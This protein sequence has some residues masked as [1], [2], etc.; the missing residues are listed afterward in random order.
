MP[1]NILVSLPHILS[2]AGKATL[3]HVD[4]RF[5]REPGSLVEPG[6]TH[7]ICEPDFADIIWARERARMQVCIWGATSGQSESQKGL[8]FILKPTRNLGGCIS[9][10]S[11]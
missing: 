5:H 1:N 6:S 9:Q 2:E 4:L 8:G 7:Q 3:D 10:V 11:K